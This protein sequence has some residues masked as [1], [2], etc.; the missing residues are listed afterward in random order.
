MTPQE[1]VSDVLL[2]MAAMAKPGVALIDIDAMAEKRTIELGA[3][4][5]NKGYKPDWAESP[6][7]TAT[8]ISVNSIIA[9]GI[10]NDY[11][12]RDGDLVN[13]DIGIKIN[14][15]CGDAALSVGVGDISNQNQRLLDVA[16]RATYFVIDQMR[17]GADTYDIGYKTERFIWNEHFEVNRNHAGHRIAEE[18]HMKPNVFHC[19]EKGYVYSKLQ[20]GEIYC[21][22]PPVTIKDAWGAR[23]EGG[24]G[25]CTRDGKCSAMFEHM[26]EITEDG[27]KILTTHFNRN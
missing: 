19:T 7:P 18:M 2:K 6:Y 16:K 23:L 25:L 27:C 26:V 13:F 10:P 21:V 9:H 20:V 22:E 24:W 17:P 8:C 14:G 4:S 12:L 5:Y 15:K 3:E 1:V 11:K